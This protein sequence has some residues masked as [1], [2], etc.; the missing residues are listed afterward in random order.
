MGAK[1]LKNIPDNTV[2]FIIV[3]HFF[4][5]FPF[6]NADGENDVTVLLAGG[7]AHHA[8]YRLNDI[9]LGTPGGKEHDGI[10]SRNVHAFR[11]TPGVGKDAAM[12]FPG[13][14]L[15]PAKKV[16]AFLR[17]HRSIDV[18]DFTRQEAFSALFI[19]RNLIDNHVHLIAN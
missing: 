3:Q 2:F 8:A 7:T 4:R 11:Q 5:R 10:Q 9:H 16:I 12:A 19:N 18:P 13:I 14:V 1:S 15:K 17:I 6:R